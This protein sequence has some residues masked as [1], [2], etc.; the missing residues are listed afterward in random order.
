MVTNQTVQHNTKPNACKYILYEIMYRL[1]L[2]NM[3]P[4]PAPTNED[5]YSSIEWLLI[6]ATLLSV[7]IPL[8]LA[9]VSH[10]IGARTTIDN[11]QFPA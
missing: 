7:G 4:F 6:V 2:L 9:V 10:V 3:Q 8:M 5:G 11:V 1:L